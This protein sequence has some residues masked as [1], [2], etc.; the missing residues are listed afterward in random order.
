MSSKQTRY[1][2]ISRNTGKTLK[3][4]A[5]REEARQWKRESGKSGLGI[6]DR[7]SRAVIS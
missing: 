1:A 6:Y 4:A 5:T 7:E 2:V 3:N